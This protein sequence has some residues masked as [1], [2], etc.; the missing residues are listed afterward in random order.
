MRNIVS[1][2]IMTMNILSIFKY[3]IIKSEQTFK[4]I[5]LQNYI[6]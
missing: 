2:L 5:N 4:K 3:K 6:L 1:L